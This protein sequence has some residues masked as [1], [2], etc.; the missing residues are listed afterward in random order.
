MNRVLM[1]L[2]LLA[3][4]LFGAPSGGVGQQDS[5]RI[6]DPR[7]VATGGVTFG[8]YVDGALVSEHTLQHTAQDAAETRFLAC[9]MLCSVE[10]RI[11]QIWRGEERYISI[12]A[13]GP[14]PEPEPPD[15]DPTPDPTPDPDP[16]PVP[17]PGQGAG[18]NAPAGHT[19]IFYA[20]GSTTDWGDQFV[21][22][23]KVAERWQSIADPDDPNGQAVQVNW[24]AGDASGFAGAAFWNDWEGDVPFLPGQ[25][26]FRMLIRFSTNWDYHSAGQKLSYYGAGDDGQASEFYILMRQSDIRWRDQGGGGESGVWST[27]DC[28][29]P[30]GRYVDVEILHNA[31]SAVGV[32]DGSLRIWVD[33]DECTGWTLLG[34]GTS[35]DDLSAPVHN[36]IGAGSTPNFSGVQLG[37]YW[38]GE[39]DV[40]TVNDWMRMGEVYISGSP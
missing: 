26:Y 14:I 22:G 35:A 30:L 28:M 38:G 36:F 10:F 6:P 24:L 31:Q 16:N 5:I 23:A 40:K 11:A 9:Q 19:V 4:L 7:F 13:P 29:I 33:G 20:D 17:D 8:V 21:Y 34:S 2:V 25:L 15:P 32:A 39:G 18:P 27:Q 1:T 12:P 37:M 3:A